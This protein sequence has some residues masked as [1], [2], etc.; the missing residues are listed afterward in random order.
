MARDRVK[1]KAATR[2]YQLRKQLRITRFKEERG[3]QVC[4][5][6]D[7]VVL[8]LDHRDPATK[9]PRLRNGWTFAAL[10]LS[11]IEDELAKCDVL[12][13]NCHRRRTAAQ[14]GWLSDVPKRSF[15]VS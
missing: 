5:V 13:A 9:D 8:E 10:P 12:C 7:V 3:C 4:G 6:R 2:A 14:Q 11:A 1:K 15:A